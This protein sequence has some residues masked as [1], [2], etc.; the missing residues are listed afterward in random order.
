MERLLLPPRHRIHK[1]D[2]AYLYFDP[3]NFVWVKANESGHLILQLL[4]KHFTEEQASRQ[5][6]ATFHL[7]E[8]EAR[9]AVAAFTAKLLT[10]G[11]LHRN[12]YVERPHPDFPKPAFPET[13]YL[14][15]TNKCNLKCPYCY[16]KTDRETKIK[17]ER[18]GLVSPT[19]DTAEM[20]DLI[21]SMVDYGVGGIFFTGGE[22]LLRPDALELVEYARLQSDAR[23]N[24]GG[25]PV[26]LQMLTNA[27]LIDDEVARQM[28]RWLDAV[29]VSL[30]GHEE[31]IHEETRGKHTFRPTLKGIQCLVQTR[32][33]LGQTRPYTVLVPVLTKKTIGFMREIYEFGMDVLGADGLAPIIFQAGDHQAFSLAQVPALDTL[34]HEL[35]KTNTYLEERRVKRG[36]AVPDRSVNRRN[37]CGVGNGEISID[38]GG[39][40]YPCQMLHYNE[41]VCGN[42]RETDVKE[43]F[44]DS[45]VMRRARSTTADTLPVCSHC[46]YRHICHAGCRSTAYNVYREFNAHNELYCKML[47]SEATRKLWLSA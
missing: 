25:E 18:K 39:F 29:T 44:Q 24:R 31:H 19:M 26:E 12:I 8:E 32:E 20:K 17:L 1:Q 37:Q 2:G 27:I 38:P 30:D 6:A 33:A 15:L 21:R 11:F 10:A 22:P 34:N 3:H 23:V 7:E 46:D 45:P 5:I 13:V 36:D 40:V 28:C 14:H 43:I 9:R 4:S 47:E 41:F 35:A 42:V 16:N